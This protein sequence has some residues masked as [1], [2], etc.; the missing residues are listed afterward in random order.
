MQTTE[1]L[2]EGRGGK[3]TPWNWNTS[4]NSND[5]SNVYGAVIKVQS[6][7]VAWRSW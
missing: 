3:Q 7:L 6:L 5:Y 1:A 2:V 4:L